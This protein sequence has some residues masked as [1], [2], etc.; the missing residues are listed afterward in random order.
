[1]GDEETL[2]FLRRVARGCRLVTSVCTGSLVLGAAGLLR[3]YRGTSHW[4]ALDQLALLGAKPVAERVVWDR[5]RVTGAGVTS[6]IDFA[7]EVVAELAG[8]TVAERVQLQMEYDPAPP[9]PGGGSPQT[10][11]PELVAALRAEGEALAARRRARDRSERP[12]GCGRWH[13]GRDASP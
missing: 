3:G 10:A 6:G 5:D 12:S 9:F 4:S 8:R 11:R 13:D 2:G 1:M 7:L